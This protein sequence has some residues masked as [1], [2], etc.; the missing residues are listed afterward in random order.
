M[1]RLLFLFVQHLLEPQHLLNPVL[2]VLVQPLLNLH[3]LQLLF[4]EAFL[5]GLQILEQPYL[6]IQDLAFHFQFFNPHIFV[7]DGV[8]F[9]LNFVIQLLILLAFVLHHH[10][11]HLLRLSR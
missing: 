9:L 4:Y 5:G 2:Q 1:L 3:E 10:S 11:H 7:L 6:L 8:N